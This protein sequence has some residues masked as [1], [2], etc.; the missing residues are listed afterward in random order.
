MPNLVAI[1][2]LGFD[3]KSILQFRGLRG[4]KTS[5]Y[6]ISTQ[7]RYAQ[8]SYWWFSKTECT[9]Y[10]VQLGSSPPIKCKYKINPLTF[11]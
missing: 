2:H 4:L 8:L 6:R 10:T 1:R 9:C 5:A 11:V 7:L 3:W